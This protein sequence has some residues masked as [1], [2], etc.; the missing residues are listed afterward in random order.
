MRLD[1]VPGLL[2]GIGHAFK[3]MVQAI[4]HALEAFW[5]AIQHLFS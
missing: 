2:H 3:V 5:H 4:W 1:L